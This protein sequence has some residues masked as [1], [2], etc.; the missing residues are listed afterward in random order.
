MSK[1]ATLVIKNGSS[2]TYSDIINSSGVYKLEPPF[3]GH[4]LVVVSEASS[5]EFGLNETM[6]FAANVDGTVS[7][8]TD[9]YVFDGTSQEKCLAEMG[10]KV[11]K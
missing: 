3:Q 1:I 9:L 6:V 7:D 5:V 8:W 11:S 4:S 10:Y 2:E